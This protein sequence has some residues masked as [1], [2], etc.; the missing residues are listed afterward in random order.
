MIPFTS[1][2]TGTRTSPKQSLSLWF[3]DRQWS[4]LAQLTPQGTAR[5]GSEQSLWSLSQCNQWLSVPRLFRALPDGFWAGWRAIP[6]KG[7]EASVLDL[8]VR[9]EVVEV[10]PEELSAVTAR[11]EGVASAAGTEDAT[12]VGTAAAQLGRNSNKSINQHRS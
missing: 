1:R 2:Q 4:R 9:P 12:A 3:L 7:A 6:T 11:G 10:V 8:G 5:R